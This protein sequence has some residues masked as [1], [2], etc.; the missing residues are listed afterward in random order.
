MEAGQASFNNK[1]GGESVQAKQLVEALGAQSNCQ[2]KEVGVVWAK[3]AVS[4]GPWPLALPCGVGTPS[5]PLQKSSQR[6][7]VGFLILSWTR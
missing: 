1:E 6:K 7:L 3:P 5:E 4:A 2:D